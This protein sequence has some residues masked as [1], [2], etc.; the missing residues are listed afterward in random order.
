ME[1]IEKFLRL[2]FLIKSNFRNLGLEIYWE[3][4]TVNEEWQGAIDPWRLR[5]I[6]VYDRIVAL[7]TSHL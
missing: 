1:L 2:L 6:H 4:D 3:E 5:Y 7:V